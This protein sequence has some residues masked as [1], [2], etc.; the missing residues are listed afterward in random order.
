MNFCEELIDYGRVVK[1]HV[2]I[3]KHDHILYL[4][5]HI[6]GVITIDNDIDKPHECEQNHNRFKR[7]PRIFHQ[8]FQESE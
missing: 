1:H 5:Q 7:L 4:M 6:I 3:P 2:V 8:G